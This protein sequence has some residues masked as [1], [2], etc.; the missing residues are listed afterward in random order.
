MTESRAQNTHRVTAGTTGMSCEVETRSMCGE[1]TAGM[2]D[3]ALVSSPPPPSMRAAA[4]LS[5]GLCACPCSQPYIVCRQ[6]PEYRRQV[7]QL[8]HYSGPGSELRAL[9][10]SGD[11]LS[12]SASVTP[13]EMAVPSGLWSYC[14][15]SGCGSS[16]LSHP[17]PLVVP[18]P[19]SL[20]LCVS[21]LG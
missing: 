3:L 11:T 13:G 14:D 16:L 5:S 2:R 9:Q 17:L 15:H 10:A 7:G 20:L 19:R 6:C 21:I 18:L 1:D 4:P 8:F 12:T